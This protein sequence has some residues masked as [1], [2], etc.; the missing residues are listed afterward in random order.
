MKPQEIDKLRMLDPNGCYGTLQQVLMDPNLNQI[1]YA[2][3][4]YHVLSKCIEEKAYLERV[5]IKLTN[6]L[7]STHLYDELDWALE[8]EGK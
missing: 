2:E 1:G 3:A 4:L 8:L 7:K 6:V 5:N